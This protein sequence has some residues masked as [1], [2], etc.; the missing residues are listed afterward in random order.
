MFHP[1]YQKFTHPG[2]NFRLYQ[3]KEVLDHLKTFLGENN[4]P[5]TIVE[6]VRFQG[7]FVIN[8][9]LEKGSIEKYGEKMKSAF[10]ALPSSGFSYGLIH[11]EWIKDMIQC[12]PTFIDELEEANTKRYTE[13]LLLE[14]TQS[15]NNRI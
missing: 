11:S 13:T 7:Y 10:K 6:G 1:N 15:K 12:Q 8:I 5:S 14:Y 4:I 3:E 2:T 9:S